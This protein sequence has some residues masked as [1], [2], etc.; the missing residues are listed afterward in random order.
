MVANRAYKNYITKVGNQSLSF[1]FD[2]LIQAGN[3]G[4]MRAIEKFDRDKGAKFSTYAVP[5]IK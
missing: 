4:L 2:D 3:F 5:W 1:E